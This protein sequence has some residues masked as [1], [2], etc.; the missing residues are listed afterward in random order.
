MQWITFKSVTYSTQTFHLTFIPVKHNQCPLA[1]STCSQIIQ[2]V[3]VVGC[4]CQIVFLVR[5]LPSPLKTLA[6]WSSWYPAEWSHVFQALVNHTAQ[7]RMGW[8]KENRLIAREERGGGGGCG[9]GQGGIEHVFEVALHIP[10]QMR[11]RT[12]G[13]GRGMGEVEWRLECGKRGRLSE[14]KRGTSVTATVLD[15]CD[16]TT[17]V[18]K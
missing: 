6:A 17:V 16:S 18:C 13:W 15:P 12:R 7:R 4:L 14:I 10:I 3:L 8:T 9:R 1:D 11:E 2:N 5:S